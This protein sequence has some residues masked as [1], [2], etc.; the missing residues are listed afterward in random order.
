MS[1]DPI[2]DLDTA[3]AGLL[4]DLGAS[5]DYAACVDMARQIRKVDNERDVIAVP[6]RP[7]ASMIFAAQRIESGDPVFDEHA[8]RMYEFYEAM[9]LYAIDESPFKWKAPVH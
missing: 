8:P 6:R 9:I 2:E 3:R 1:D 7:T 5:A 4:Y